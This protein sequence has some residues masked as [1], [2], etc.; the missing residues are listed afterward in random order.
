MKRIADVTAGG[1]A[2]GMNAAIRSVAG[3]A[4]F[5]GLEVLGVERGYA[6]LIEGKMRSL[7]IRSV[8]ARSC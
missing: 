1:G 5:N 4:L 3:T 8:R 7:D 6:G 2:P